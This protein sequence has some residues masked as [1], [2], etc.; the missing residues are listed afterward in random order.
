MV[1]VQLIRA[2]H[3][4]YLGPT[5]SASADMGCRPFAVAYYPL[6]RRC[7]ARKIGSRYIP[8]HV[9]ELDCFSIRLIQFF[10]TVLCNVFVVMLVVCCSKG[11]CRP[12][13]AIAHLVKT[14]QDVTVLEGC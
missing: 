2:N 8:P 10:R 14:R 7:G 4:P 1:L 5:T 6:H 12:A 3:S 11:Q 9:V 13:N